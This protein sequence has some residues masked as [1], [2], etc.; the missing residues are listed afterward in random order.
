MGALQTQATGKE[1]TIWQDETIYFLMVDR[2]N[3][4]DKSNDFD[5]DPNDPKAYHG[6][7]FKGII[8][9]LDYLKSMGFT[10]IWMTPVFDN[11]KG[12]YH[13]Y[14]IN[15]FYKTDE[16]FGTIDEFKQ[17]VK[18][19][20]KRDIKIILDFVVNH[21]GPSHPWQMDPEKLGW[22]HEKKPIVNWESQDE[23]ENNWLYDLPDFNQ[24][25]PDVR[26]FLLDAAKWWI[27]ETGV[28]GYRLD[29]V[30]H[31]PVSFWEEFSKEV[32]AQKEDFYLIGEVWT[33]DP[34]YI[35]QYDKAGIDGFVDFPLHEQLRE[36]FAKPDQTLDWLF[37]TAARNKVLYEDPYLMGTFID[38]HDMVRFTR[39]VLLA[40]EDPVARWKLALAYMYTAPGIP[41]IYYGSEIAMD[42]ANDPDNR[43]LMDFTADNGLV[44]YISKLGELREKRISLTRG[45]MEKLHEKDGM[46]VYKRDYKGE[47][48]LI[49]INNTSK[50]QK[51]TIPIE[52]LGENKRL[53]G[54][55]IGY[56]GQALDDGYEL[57]LE[58]GVAE[59]YSLEEQT[60]NSIPIIFGT[61]AFL[62]A[63]TG[64]FFFRNRARK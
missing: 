50:G 60:S 26:K 51:V 41:I 37:S 8:A 19:A 43:R 22:F 33:D 53:Q 59:I 39:E 4:G 15:D 2:F 52:K 46:A 54:L 7:D 47:T 31:V 21:V 23:L 36:A 64:L 17:L 24:D 5:S 30:R 45:D 34:N 44:E 62:A 9:K 56:S 48:T 25:N 13:G 55:L 3:N 16:H 38:N 63:A 6:G 32:K 35:A 10:A 18:E 14:W 57:S 20:H 28:D 11:E 12:G 40:K 29:T 42:G 49:A 1:K 58:S 61:A 27:N